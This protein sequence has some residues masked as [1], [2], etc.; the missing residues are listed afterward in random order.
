MV[1]T[2]RRGTSSSIVFSEGQIKL[3]YVVHGSDSEDGG[4]PLIPGDQGLQS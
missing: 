4:G 2:A 3:T 1:H